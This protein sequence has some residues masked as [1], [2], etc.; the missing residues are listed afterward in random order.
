VRRRDLY[1]G[2]HID[3]GYYVL[4]GR[5]GDDNAIVVHGPVPDEKTAIE[6]D[7]QLKTRT[8]RETSIAFVTSIPVG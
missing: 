5:T 1:G 4:D 3:P 2:Q 6:L 7:A 8:R